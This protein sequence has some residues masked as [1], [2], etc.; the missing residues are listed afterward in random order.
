M[1]SVR[2]KKAG[3]HQSAVEIRLFRFHAAS[4]N[5]GDAMKEESKQPEALRLA[6]ALRH[7]SKWMDRGV[8]DSTAKNAAEELIRLQAE[9]DEL[10]DTVQ[11]CERWAV[12]HGS[13]PSLSAQ[14]A[15]SCIQ[16]Y[17]GITEVTD[18]Y[19][20]G[21]RPDTFNPFARIAELEEMLRKECQHS[22]NETRRA[23]QMSQQHSTQ[24]ALNKEAREELARA[25]GSNAPTHS[26]HRACDLL[27][28]TLGTLIG[29]Q[30]KI[31]YTDKSP[32]A[33]LVSEAVEF[34]QPWPEKLPNAPQSADQWMDAKRWSI[35]ANHWSKADFKFD[36]NGFL[37]RISLV[38]D[39][40]KQGRGANFISREFDKA[41]EFKATPGRAPKAIDKAQGVSE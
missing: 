24:P 14:E 41:I 17:P 8:E 10:R 29:F 6:G 13:K 11:F 30:A 2:L 25:T 21:K 23:D 37:S 20:D 27:S 31:G 5:F 35:V 34:L 38:I 18:S 16:H 22:A 32:I 40:T 1:H 26:L 28:L 4:L 12:H 36:R 15:L 33:K 39:L 9:N 3:F 7:E 19:A